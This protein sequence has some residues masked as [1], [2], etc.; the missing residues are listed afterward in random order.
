[1]NTRG[2]GVMV[3]ASDLGSDVERCVGSSPIPRTKK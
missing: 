1:M 2:G 3:A